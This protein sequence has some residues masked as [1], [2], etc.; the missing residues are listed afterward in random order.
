MQNK[1]SMRLLPVVM[2]VIA[3]LIAFKIADFGFGEDS[4]GGAALAQ[5]TE[6]AA[7]A[8]DEAANDETLDPEATGEILTEE[9]EPVADRNREFSAAEREVLESLLTRRQQLDEREREV[10]LREK[11]LEAAEKRVEER[12]AELKAIEARIE[13]SLGKQEEERKAQLQNLV[14]MYENM[15]PKEAARIF[16]RLDMSVLLGVVQQMKTRKMAPILARMDSAVAQRLTVELAR[17]AAQ[18]AAQ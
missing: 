11:L 6:P 9:E 10:Q 14:S 3:A 17:L 12:V 7:D 13:Q 16:D 1:P 8:P 5:E 2:L 18:R 15:K 4:A